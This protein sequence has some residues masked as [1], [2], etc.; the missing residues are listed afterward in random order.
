MN[1]TS[2]D[3]GL[4]I[5][6]L[7]DAIRHGQ[8]FGISLRPVSASMPGY[9]NYAETILP[10]YGLSNS[11]VQH[12]GT[13]DFGTEAAAQKALLDVGARG[14]PRFVASILRSLQDSLQN[15]FFGGDQ[16]GMDL[17]SW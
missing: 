3:H 15:K 16:T 10:G 17:E 4:T 8:I 7:L 5:E 13:V 12:Q 1:Y 14:V 11:S 6:N 9:R 2:I